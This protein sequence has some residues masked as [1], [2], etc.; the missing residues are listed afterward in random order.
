MKQ[1]AIMDKIQKEMMPGVITKTGFLGD[2]KR[3]LID[4]LDG[5]NAEVS[6]L[7]LSHE[8]IAKRMKEL[9]DAGKKGLG[10]FIKVFEKFEVKVDSVRGKLPCPFMH[11]AVYSKVNTTVKNISSG[12]EIL[13]TDLNIHMIESHGFYEGNNAVFRQDPKIL[14]E[15][16]EI[17]KQ[18]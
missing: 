11:G 8:L 14:S 9:S 16:L 4:I 13:Y 17:Q 6:N 5:H 7:G 1:T 2:D 15:V 10:L 3:N 18:E 12:R